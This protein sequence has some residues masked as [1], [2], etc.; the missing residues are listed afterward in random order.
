MNPMFEAK[1]Q[2]GASQ[3]GASGER[4]SGRLPLEDIEKLVEKVR[5]SGIAE[6]GVRQGDLEIVVKAKYG[7]PALP[8][9]A[10]LEVRTS[11]EPTTRAGLDIFIDATPEKVLHMVRSPIVG[12]FYEAPT[13]GEAP[14]VKVGDRVREGQTLCIVEAMKLMNEIP[15]EVS[16]EVVEVL[17]G[18]GE[19]TQYDQ[20]L[21]LLRPET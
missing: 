6:L 5:E 13:P 7:H 15:A 9:D 11:P 3:K 18:D 4:R 2:G 21:F 17:T 12:V 1:T 20:P 8:Q 16:G 10:R 14:F 19:G